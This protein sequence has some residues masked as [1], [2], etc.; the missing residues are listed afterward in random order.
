MTRPMSLTIAVVLQWIAAIFGIIGG[1]FLL[2][3]AGAMGSQTVRDGVNR[4]LAD[5][6]FGEITAATLAWGTLAAGIFT[7]FIAVIR[8]IVAVSLARGHNWAR[9][10]ITVFVALS[11]LG[12]IFELFQGGGAFW[13]GIGTIIVELVILWL[14][15]NRTSTAYIK[16]KTAERALMRS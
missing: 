1:F 10:L 3:A 12:A 9:L 15:W 16:V 4:A 8:I 2:G 6:G 5:G 11:L 14:M 13:R 7:V